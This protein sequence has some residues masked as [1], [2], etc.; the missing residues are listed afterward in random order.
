MIVRS[1]H[2]PG[3]S[4]ISM[5]LCVGAAA[6][7]AAWAQDDASLHAAAPPAHA[8]WLDSLDLN[9]ATQDFGAP[10]AGHSVDLAPMTLNGVVYPHGFGT[11]A[12]SNLEVYLKGAATQFVSMV[13][14][15]DEK[16]AKGSV[17]F[18]VWVDGKRVANT[19]VLRAGGKPVRLSADLTGAKHMTLKVTDAGDGIDSDHADWAGAMILLA[20]NATDKPTTGPAEVV[21]PPNIIF[22]ESTQT[23]IHGARI[24]GATPGHDFLFLIPAT[25][26]GPLHYDAAPLPA[27]LSLDHTTGI[28][29]GKL[30]GPGRWN[31]KLTVTGPGGTATENLVI[32]G[33]LHQLALTPPMGW[34]SWNVWAGAIDA[35]KVR[36]A[37]DYMIKSGLAAHGFQ[38]INIDDTWEAGRNANGE[39]QTNARFP[40]MKAL[41]DYVHSK[42]LKIGIYSS[43]GPKTCGGYEASY[44][45]EQQD[46][47]TYAKW[48]MDY[49]KYDWCSYGGIAKGNS[50]D[51]MRKPYK[52]MAKA[53]ENSGRDIVFSFC[54]YGMGDVWQWGAR[55][56]GNTWRTTGDINDSWGSLQ[57]NAF[58]QS[59]H[60]R[61]AGPGHWNDPDM[62]VVGRVGWGNPHPSHL[63]PNEQLLHITM[64][65]LQS[66]PLLI[67][68]DMSRLDPFTTALLSNDE[69]LAVN[70]DPL[71]T[72]AGRMSQDGE[73][74]VWARNLAD[75]SM[76]VGLFNRG[77]EAAPVTAHWDDLELIGT[78][79]VRDLWLHKDLGDSTDSFTA[80][81]PAHGAMLL[82]IGPGRRGM[83][84]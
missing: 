26:Q 72:P 29:S 5:L 25:G 74:E 80:T 49:L 35:Q 53:L 76:A 45:H 84:F 7:G 11:H 68:C 30:A 46:A 32:V 13:G 37:A 33:G 19:D 78:Q 12:N 43:P 1:H 52:V 18:E 69:V 50:L 47:N 83:V 14:V 24:T 56:G 73:T 4:L 36:D 22:P 8:V 58:S 64:W 44:Q 62:L 21:P 75:G 79:P 2:R 38:Y 60:E 77:G 42:G 48:G 41:A 16:T 27:G 28:I 15:D 63:T 23:A 51:E 39:I 57:G 9:N 59:G 81:V 71:G 67:G 66:A 3:A 10:Q 82:K 31:V 20:A 55:T 70:Q 17:T 54:Q 6:H 65:C 34:N 61:F 40:D